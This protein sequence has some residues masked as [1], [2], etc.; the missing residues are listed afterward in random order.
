[1]GG[2]VVN[3]GYRNEDHSY[4]GLLACTTVNKVGSGQWELT[5]TGSTAGIVVKEGTLKIR[6]FTGVTTSSSLTVEAGGTLIGRGTTQSILVKKGATVCP[7]TDATNCNELATSGHF[8]AYGG[9]TLLFK[10]NKSTNDQITVGG[11]LR[12]NGDTIRIVPKDGRTFMEGES[13]Q[14]FNGTMNGSS[15]WVIDG[16][17]YVWDDSQ[18]ISSGKLICKGTTDGIDGIMVDEPDN[19]RYFDAQGMEVTKKQMRRHQV[20]IERTVTNGRVRIL[21]IR[22]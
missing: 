22:K 16:G 6:N 10:V 4:A 14:L 12:L 21:K 2:K 17:G 19:T 1:M 3:V 15:K 9:S 11:T 13:L 20:Y 7:G 18:L 8:I 5:G